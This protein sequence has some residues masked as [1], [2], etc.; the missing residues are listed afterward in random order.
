MGPVEAPLVEIVRKRTNQV[1]ATRDIELTDGLKA[2]LKSWLQ[3]APS[4]ISKTGFFSPDTYVVNFSSEVSK[5]FANGTAE[6]MMSRLGDVHATA[7]TSSGHRIIEQGVLTRTASINPGLVWQ[8]AAVVTGQRFLADINKNL[9]RLNEAIDC[10]KRL[11]EADQIGVVLA[12]FDRLQEIIQALNQGNWTLDDAKRWIG[13]LDQ[14]DFECARIV[15]AGLARV[16]DYP[17]KASGM[18][19]GTFRVNQNNVNR[20]V[21]NTADFG[22]DFE[23]WMAAVCIRATVM[24]IRGGLPIG[25][26]ELPTRSASCKADI[27]S[28]REAN[29]KYQEAVKKCASSLKGRTLFSFE[30]TE[31][32]AQGKLVSC[33]DS[34]FEQNRSRLKTNKRLL[35]AV[36]DALRLQND[37]TGRELRLEVELGA[38]GSV[39]AVRR[40]LVPDET[41][42]D[43]TRS[44]KA[45]SSITTTLNLSGDSHDFTG[46]SS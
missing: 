25:K 15:K 8:L 21:Q 37:A 3:H 38:D 41:G 45:S 13:V 19:L 29:E 4:L 20:I 6:L 28:L 42:N 16:A 23:I 40:V 24:Q 43:M 22:R 12:S 46:F 36:N 9:N 5:A 31:S 18:D 32:A 14:L 26:S 1:A 39:T 34:T 30:S 44:A 27:G 11:A 7:V 2:N 33:S 10:L 35:M 17:T